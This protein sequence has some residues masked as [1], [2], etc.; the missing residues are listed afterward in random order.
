MW[1]YEILLI[2]LDTPNNKVIFLMWLY[3]A[4]SWC[5]VLKKQS[6]YQM[7]TRW[8]RDMFPWGA[9]ICLPGGPPPGGVWSQH[10]SLSHG[11]RAQLPLKLSLRG[12]RP[13]IGG[14]SSGTPMVG[15]SNE[16]LS[17]DRWRCLSG[18]LV[19]VPHLPQLPLPREQLSLQLDLDWDS[20]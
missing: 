13:Q 12:P 18:R 19:R 3:C 10:L 9:G 11:L 15:F 8:W 20:T 6:V 16:K 14:G 5:S 4:L 2:R 1:C 17:G 7:D